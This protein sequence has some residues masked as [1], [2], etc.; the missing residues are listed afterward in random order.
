MVYCRFLVISGEATKTLYL[1][2]GTNFTGG[3]AELKRGIL[4]LD[5][6][7]ITATMP[8]RGVKWKFNPPLVSHQE[9]IWE[10]T[11]RLVRKPL[12]SIM[13]DRKMRTLTEKVLRHFYAKY[14]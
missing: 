11:I 13:E 3:Y 1:D 12:M 8:K 14:N 4:R 6:A 7:Q 5:K 2:N 9:G 10:S